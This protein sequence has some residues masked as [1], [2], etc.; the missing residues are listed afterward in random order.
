MFAIKPASVELSV[1][2]LMVLRAFDWQAQQ[3]VSVPANLCE[4]LF[5][6]QTVTLYDKPAHLGHGP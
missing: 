3:E 1:Y 2:V 6:K 5:P 4:S